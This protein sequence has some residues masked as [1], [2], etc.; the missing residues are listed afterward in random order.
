MN[1]ADVKI[2][3]YTSNP[4]GLLISQEMAGRLN[5]V[6]NSLPPKCK[7]IF[8]LLR[9]DGLER[10]KVAEILNVSPKT[11]DAQVAI[12]VQKIAEALGMDLTDKRNRLMISF[13]LFEV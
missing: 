10:K 11:I 4:E 5:A 6:V 13:F 3:D 2:A 9:E 12:A 7:I 1:E 8:K